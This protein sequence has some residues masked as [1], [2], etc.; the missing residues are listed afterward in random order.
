VY[1]LGP[2][3]HRLLALDRARPRYREPTVTFTDHTLAITQL[4]VD[5]TDAARAG[6]F[7]VLVC[8]NEPR[9]W[10]TF[11][12]MGAPA[13][14]RPDLFVTLGV[15]EYERRFFCE[16]D[17]GTEHLPAVLRK[18]RQYESYYASGAEQAAH[19]VFP[20]VAWLVPDPTR[21]RRIRDAVT[22]DR[23]LTDRLFV[24]TAVDRAIDMLVGA[25]P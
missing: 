8:Q 14:L 5:V 16:V 11:A 3:G 2:V 21:A 15:G 4:V 9:C 24:V 22:A 1:A 20:R 12:T 7:D 6:R 25:T 18:C 23:R 17:R 13:V 10:R 19:G